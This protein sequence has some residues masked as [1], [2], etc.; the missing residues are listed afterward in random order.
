MPS[1]GSEVTGSNWQ[2]PPFNRWAYWHVSEILPVYRVS[3]GHGPV[4][5]LSPS[6]ASVDVPSV[7][8]AR[9]DNSAGTVGEVMADTFTDAYLVLQDGALVT[10][11]YGPEGAPGRAHAL[12]SVSK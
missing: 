2:D 4:R 1:E 3:R 8:T 10:E 12:M 7:A 6:G 11:W 5:P 9:V